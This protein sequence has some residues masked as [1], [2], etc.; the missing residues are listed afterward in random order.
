MKA[1]EFRKP[2]DDEFELIQTVCIRNPPLH[3]NHMINNCLIS[4]ET[5]PG[6]F[7]VCILVTGRE[8]IYRGVSRR[9]YKDRHNPIRG[10]ML[11]LRRA[12]LYS[13]PV[14]IPGEYADQETVFLG[15]PQEEAR[16][17]VDRY[18]QERSWQERHGDTKM[19]C[20]TQTDQDIWIS[21][22]ND[23]PID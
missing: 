23:I 19:G 22:G 11:A 3:F 6:G 18:R 4:Y 21:E 17:R 12:V 13:S 2:T 5:L 1:E 9:S 10:R 8:Q 14:V 15:S 20:G 7:T 16:E